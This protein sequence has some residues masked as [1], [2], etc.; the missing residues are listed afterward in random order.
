MFEFS[1]QFERSEVGPEIFDVCIVGSAAS[2]GT[3][4]AHLAQRGV[5]VAV[6]K[7]GPPVSM[8]ASHD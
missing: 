3:L 7:G 2:R 5:Q 4:A 1:R 6:V 8:F